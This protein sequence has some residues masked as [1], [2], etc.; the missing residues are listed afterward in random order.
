MNKKGFTLIDLLCVIVLLALI[1][2]LATTGIMS[3][4][5]SSKENMYCAKV[6]IIENIAKE[7]AVKYEKE[8][9]NSTDLYNGYKSIKIKV[10][11]LVLSG[12]LEA[13]KDNNVLSPID[14]SIMNDIEIIIYL[15]N[16]RINAY[17]DNNIC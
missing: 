7:Y 6:E 11:D 5:K 17:I 3:L 8:L 9:N 16:N 12:D 15:K 10:N 1:T 2:V 13:D 4:S 14:N